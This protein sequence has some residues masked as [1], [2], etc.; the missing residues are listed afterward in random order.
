MST[1]NTSPKT[2]SGNQNFL[3]LIIL[4]SC[5]ILAGLLIAGA[6]KYK[7]RS[8]QVIRVTGSAEKDFGSDLIAW[9]GSYN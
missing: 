3:G 1:E 4:G 5:I 8:K 9:N 2:G 6:Y 7:F